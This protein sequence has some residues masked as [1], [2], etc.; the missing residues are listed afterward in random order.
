MYFIYSSLL[1]FHRS[2]RLSL[3]ISFFEIW[4]SHPLFKLEGGGLIFISWKGPVEN[5]VHYC[6]WT[7]I[8]SHFTLSLT[9]VSINNL[10]QKALTESVILKNCFFVS[11]GHPA[12]TSSYP[13]GHRAIDLGHNPSHTGLMVEFEWCSFTEASL[14]AGLK[15]SFDC[16]SIWALPTV[17]I[18]TGKMLFYL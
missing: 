10:T 16:S 3:H 11:N 4:T 17:A 15:W 18:W 1:F 14:T 13:L 8:E 9:H 7:L 2:P 6:H 12:N 5:D